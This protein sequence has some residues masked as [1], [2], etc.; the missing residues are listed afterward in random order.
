MQPNYEVEMRLNVRTPMRDG[1]E[2]SS[3]IYLPKAPGKFPT[4]LMRTPYD[5]NAPGM[6]ESGMK[7][8]NHGYACVIQDV[9]GRWD[10][11]GVHYALFNHGPD[12]FD[13]QEWI[14][15]Q[16]WSDGKIGM[17]GGSYVGW[18][19][20]AERASSQP[21]PDVHC[22]E[23]DVLRPVLGPDPSRRG[24]AAQ[25]RA[26]LGDADQWADG[27]EHRVSQLD[28]GVSDGTADRHGPSLRVGSSSSGRTG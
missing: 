28:R 10:S 9:R 6:I 7:L 26:D 12:G 22:A 3:D 20:V 8:A 18:V 11:D 4:V 13:T 14:G 24:L 15:Q 2:L 5:N 25:R 16:E 19:Q 23:G 27:A 17:S 1:V 21:V